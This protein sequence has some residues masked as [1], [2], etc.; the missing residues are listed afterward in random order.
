MS[1]R[2]GMAGTPRRIDLTGQQFGRLTVLHEDGQTTKSE[3]RWA[4]R[5]ECGGT[6]TVRAGH[7]KRGIVASCGCYRREWAVARMTIHG[8]S[9]TRAW[10]A[11]NH[12]RH[13][14]LNP[15]DAAFA[16][17]GGRGISICPQW[18]IFENFHADMGQPPAGRSLDRIDV[19]GNYE[20]GNCRWATDFEQS[21]NRRNVVSIEVSGRSQTVAEWARETGVNPSTILYRYR[22][23]NTGLDLFRPVGAVG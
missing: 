1:G 12:M 20:P 22:H 23:G 9:K 3:I 18:L 7:L 11:W 19:N 6:K 15:K 10:Q 5:C 16:D 13:R 4:C 17:Y 14:C 2:P 8:L 21:Q